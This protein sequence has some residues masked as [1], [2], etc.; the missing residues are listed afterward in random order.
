MVKTFWNEQWKEIEFIEEGKPRQ[1]NYAISNY[2]RV[3]SFTD[4]IETGKLLNCGI[5]NGYKT[6]TVGS[7]K[8]KF[9]RCIHKLVAHYFLSDPEPDQKYVIHYDFDKLNNSA[10]N[11]Q[12]AN[13]KQLTEHLEQ[14]PTVIN[15]RKN[16]A[17]RKKGPKLTE[18]KVKRLKKVINAPER[19]R[20][21]KQIAKRYGISEALLYRIKRGEDWAHI[22]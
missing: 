10:K 7:H 19:K 3:I 18:T 17:R 13:N 9:G 8:A 20:T 12:W 2:G 5:T 22:N 6:L 15:A 14:N 11:L 4:D 1:K 16:P 21:Y